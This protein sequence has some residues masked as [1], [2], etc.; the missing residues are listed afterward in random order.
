MGLSPYAGVVTG[1]GDEKRSEDLAPGDAIRNAAGGGDLRVVK[2]LNSPA[3]GMMRVCAEGGVILDL[4]GDQPVLSENGPVAAQ[5]LA[6]GVGLRGA[7]G[8]VK[9]TAVEAL[10]GD[11][12]VYDVVV[13]NAG[14][15]GA[16]MFAGGLAVGAG[17]R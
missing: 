7:D 10:M 17:T 8:I 6:P 3:V 16:W 2:C 12:M 1:A 5:S 11:Y 4:T 13:E 15:D 14:A 9:C